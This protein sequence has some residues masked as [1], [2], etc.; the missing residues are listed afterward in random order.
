MFISFM[1]VF[2]EKNDQSYV[3]K[4]DEIATSLMYISYKDFSGL[5]NGINILLAV[6][7]E[8]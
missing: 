3:D 7:Y 8:D 2:R 1:V 5:K 4:I 6:F